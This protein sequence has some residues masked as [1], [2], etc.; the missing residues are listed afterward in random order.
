MTDEAP[1]AREIEERVFEIAPRAVLALAEG[2]DVRLGE[3]APGIRA[4]LRLGSPDA[5]PKRRRTQKEIVGEA[6]T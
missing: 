6:L 4:V 5:R 1:A 3:I 2:N